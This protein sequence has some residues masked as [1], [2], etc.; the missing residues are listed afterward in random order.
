MV[1]VTRSREERHKVR[2]VPG[3]LALIA[4]PLAGAA[5][6]LTVVCSVDDPVVGPR[7]P[8]KASVL[9]DTPEAG[10][11]HYAW[12]AN[13]GSLDR[14]NTATVEWNPNGASAGSYTL[15]VVVTGPGES[16]GA[17]SVVV[18]VGSEER[19]APSPGAGFTRET[20]S[21]MLIQG[22]KEAEHFGLYSYLL[23]GAEPNSSNRERYRKFLE[24]F[25]AT[26]LPYQPLN[27]YFSP[28]QLNIAYLPIET[29]V[30]TRFDSQWVLDNYDYERARFLLASIPGVHG[31]GPFIVSSDSPLEGPGHTPKRYLLEDL[32]TVPLTIVEFWVK[33]FRIQTSQETWDRATLSGVAVRLRTAIEIAAIGLPE[34]RASINGLLTWK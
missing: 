31:D 3:L 17:C 33:Q 11:L 22:K 25:L 2:I 32:T 34:V 12:K 6:P 9:G 15:S 8:V 30:P 18:I 21:A 20:R 14:T 1:V 13:G 10:S 16:T 29:D 19:S 23:L 27:R 5:T 28:Q 7:Q 24:S 4:L 26:V